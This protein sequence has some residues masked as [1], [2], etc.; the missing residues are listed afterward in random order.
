MLESLNRDKEGTPRD[1]L[2][3]IRRSVREFVGEAP[4]FDDLTMLCVEY[5]GAEAES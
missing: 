5:R 4:Q 2:E 3:G 1:I